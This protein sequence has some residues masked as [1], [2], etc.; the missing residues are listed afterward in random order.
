MVISRGHHGPATCVLAR[1]DLLRGL[2]YRRLKRQ[3]QSEKCDN[4]GPYAD[5]ALVHAPSHNQ[6]P[7][8]CVC[9]SSSYHMS[10]TACLGPP[11]VQGI[12]VIVGECSSGEGVVWIQICLVFEP[13]CGLRHRSLSNRSERADAL[14]ACLGCPLLMKHFMYR[15]RTLEGSFRCAGPYCPGY[16]IKKLYRPFHRIL[17]RFGVGKCYQPSERCCVCFLCLDIVSLPKKKKKHSS[18]ARIL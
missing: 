13:S 4:L 16:V 3:M 10:G 1:S 8:L 11:A 9:S 17:G 7:E 12:G 14:V 6:S 2:C 18:T 5:L 15:L